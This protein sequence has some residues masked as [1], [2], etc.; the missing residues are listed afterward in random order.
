MTNEALQEYANFVYREVFKEK[1]KFPV[2]WNSK[3]KQTLGWYRTGKEKSSKKI[4]D[5]IEINPV[6][7]NNL[8][9]LTDVLIHE[10]CHYY[11]DKNKKPA[12]D[13]DMEFLDLLEKTQSM[14]ACAYRKSKTGIEYH[15]YEEY[16]ASCACG[17]KQKILYEVMYWGCMPVCECPNCKKI[18]SFKNTNKDKKTPYTP[19]K[20]VKRLTKQYFKTKTSD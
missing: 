17:Y 5:R 14:P 7:K 15:I 11:Q 6:L 16:T 4:P 3:F 10:F 12:L 1:L 9:L 19:S 2:V 18:L 8:Y 13:T 20:T